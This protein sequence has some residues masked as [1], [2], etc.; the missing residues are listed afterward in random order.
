MS[1]LDLADAGNRNRQVTIER[2]T[3][4]QNTHNEEVQTWETHKVRMAAMKPAP[5]T[6]R[7]ESAETAAS[8]PMHFFFLWEPDLVDV[9]DRLSFE[10]R[11]FYVVAVEEIG[12]RE[13]YRVLATARTEGEA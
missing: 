4:T 3:T 8:A 11:T 1:V 10:G 2:F 9:E 7:F 5:G 6:E 13:G 12:F